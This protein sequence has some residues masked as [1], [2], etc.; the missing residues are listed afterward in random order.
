VEYVA[1]LDFGGTSVKIG[2]VDAA[3]TIHA[4]DAVAVD[5]RASFATTMEALVAG[6][7]SVVAHAGVTI[8]GIGAGTPGFSDRETGILVEGCRNIPNLQGNA[9]GTYLHRAFGVPSVVDNDA[10]AAAAGEL[11]FG[12]G[13]RF[14][15]FVL[16]TLGTGVGGGLVL[17][18]RVY[19]GARGFAG[20]IGHV[21][22]D[23]NGTWCN[24]GTRGCLEQYASATAMARLYTEKVQKRG[25]RTVEPVTART[26]FD[27]AEAGDPAA[28][29]VIES[30]AERIAQSFGS[31]L[32]TL[33][34]QACV[35]GGGVS[36]AGD[37]IAGPVRR[38][39]PDYGWPLVLT[40]VEVVLAE[41]GN[42]AGIL[43]AAAGILDELYATMSAPP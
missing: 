29:D 9:I 19:R 17:D 30:A 20:E 10:T 39:L 25:G 38:H 3:G 16:M 2:I 36:Q 15:S 7:R 6:L 4:K 18:G 32:N 33:N 5:P 12:V 34:L 14:R 26:V 11:R 1:G 21:S 27:A 24:C 37:A 43:G 42:D 31:L 41:L 35:L 8:S 28:R 40:G 23:P 13:R 22:L